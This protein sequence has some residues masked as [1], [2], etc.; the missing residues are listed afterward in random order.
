[1]IVAI[2]TAKL[3]STRLPDKVLLPILGEP[4]LWHIV[5][6]VRASKVNRVVVA[7]TIH[8]KEIKAFCRENKIDFYAGSEND[9]LD[10]IYKTAR[11]F[12]L[13]DIVVRVWGDAPLIDP[14]I[15][16]LCVKVYKAN[17]YNYLTNTGYPKGLNVAVVSFGSLEKAWREIRS[18]QKRHWIHK[19]FVENADKYNVGE[20]R[21]KK[22]LSYL[23]WSV[24]YESQLEWVRGIYRKLSKEGRVFGWEEALEFI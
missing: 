2:I 17:D 14:E 11:H 6:R 10:R 4:M 3:K 15:I 23:D 20:V 16:D 9:I 7:T 8:D 21:F 5:N 1:M 18:P 12:P 24:D 13:T 22:D 19:Y